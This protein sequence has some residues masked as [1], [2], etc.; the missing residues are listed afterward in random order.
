MF[1]KYDFYFT[2]IFSATMI[3][4][5]KMNSIITLIIKSMHFDKNVEMHDIL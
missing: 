2:L 4:S 3:N 5:I 1:V